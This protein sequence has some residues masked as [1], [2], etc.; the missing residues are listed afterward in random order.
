MN[1]C[2]A[3]NFQIIE[4]KPVNA[5]LDFQGEIIQGSGGIKYETDPTVPAWAKEPIKPSYT[6]DEV[7]A[8]PII[9]KIADIDLSDDISAEEMQDSLS[10]YPV[11]QLSRRPN[12][13]SEELELVGKVG[14]IGI[15][16]VGAGASFYRCVS[17][18]KHPQ[19]IGEFKYE[20]EYLGSNVSCE[21][22][23][24]NLTNLDYPGGAKLSGNMVYSDGSNGKTL[25]LRVAGSMPLVEIPLKTDIADEIEVDENGD[26][27]NSDKIASV[28]CVYDLFNTYDNNIL[29][30]LGGDENV[31]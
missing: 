4:E 12:L 28:K 14:Q 3:L 10:V 24:Y 16:K 19:Y 8:V 25:Y 5:E 29:A 9:R 1:Q 31:E 23:P 13:D 18:T 26:L 11:A 17:V 15:Y 7:G 30:I 27:A 21:Y 22:I 2:K 20:W 6:A